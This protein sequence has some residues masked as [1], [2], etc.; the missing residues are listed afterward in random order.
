MFRM[1][2]TPRAQD[3]HDCRD[4]V[5]PG[6]GREGGLGHAG[7][8]ATQEQLPR[9]G[10]S[11]VGTTYSAGLKHNYPMPVLNFPQTIRAYAVY[12]FKWHPKQ[13]SALTGSSLRKPSEPNPP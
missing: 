3:A 9:S 11:Q 13:R 2:G 6:T 12:Y 8:R 4:K 5:R 10:A 7:G 1:N